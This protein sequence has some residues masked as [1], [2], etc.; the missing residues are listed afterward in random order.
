MTCEDC[1]Y[2][3]ICHIRIDGIIFFPII[4][5]KISKIPMCCTEFKDIENLF[6]ESKVKNIIFDTDGIAFDERA[7]GK[8]VFLTREEAEKKLEE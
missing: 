4:N 6:Y 3:D 7:I 1:F 5:G 2:F 8:S